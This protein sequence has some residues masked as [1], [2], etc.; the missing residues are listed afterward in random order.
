MVGVRLECEAE[1]RNGLASQCTTESGGNFSCHGAFAD[2]VGS[3]DGFNDTKWHV[4][5]VRRLEKRSGILRKTRA[6]KTR[7]GMQKFW[8]D[9]IIKPNA[10]GDILHIRAN[11]FGKISHLIDE[12]DLRGEKR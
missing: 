3:D 6:S 9:P 12:R 8:P 10:A 2:I 5:V 7:A 4:I 11:F 1:H